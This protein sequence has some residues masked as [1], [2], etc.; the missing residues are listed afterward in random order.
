MCPHQDRVYTCRF[1]QN[2]YTFSIREYTHMEKLFDTYTQANKLACSR[3]GA[4]TRTV[5]TL[6]GSYRTSIPFPFVSTLT[7]K[8]FSTPIHKLIN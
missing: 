4:L 1:L 8:S 5:Y 7:W 6:V 3:S 2:Q